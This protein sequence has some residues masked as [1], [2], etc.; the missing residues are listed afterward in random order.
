M[1]NTTV[2]TIA[3]YN[4]SFAGDKGLDPKRPDVYESEA[5]FHLSNKSSDPR[6]FWL[7]AL[8]LV[9]MFWSKVPT[10]SAMGLQEMNK[11]A[12]SKSGSGAVAAAVKAINPAFHTA[13]EEVVVKPGIK[14]AIT[15]IWNS[16]KLGVEKKKYISDLDTGRPILMVLTEAGYLLIA[17]HAPHGFSNAPEILNKKIKEFVKNQKIDQNKIFIMGDFNDRLDT[18]K[19]ID[20]D[21]NGKIQLGYKGKAPK[22]CCHNW[23]SSCTAKRYISDS[24]ICDPKG[25]PTAG[26]GV[27]KVMGSEGNIK[28]YRMHGDKV[29]GSNPVGNIQTYPPGRKGASK[30]SDHEMVIADFSEKKVAAKPTKSTTRRKARS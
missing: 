4:M 22:S 17:L 26:P 1:A 10:A 23:D 29:F 13:T 3:T 8:E 12:T 19:K 20:L 18:L 28:N 30:E 7:N 5:A 9:K 11:T 15:I 25:Q 14:P 2:H 16:E 27:R 21:I 24:Q 6:K